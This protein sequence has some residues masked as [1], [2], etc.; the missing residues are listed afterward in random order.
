LRLQTAPLFR[1]KLSVNSNVR[2][3]L[4][5][6]HSRKSLTSD[7]GLLQGRSGS[8]DKVRH[9]LEKRPHDGSTLQQRPRLPAELTYGVLLGV[10]EN[11]LKVSK[12]GHEAAQF[13]IAQS[14]LQPVL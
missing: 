3:P 1:S 14:Q 5:V 13:T 10:L 7:S 9:C 8:S 11:S 2:C 6:R 12:V 4:Y